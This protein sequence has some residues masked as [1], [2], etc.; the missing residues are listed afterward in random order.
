VPLAVC[1]QIHFMHI[2]YYHYHATS[3][4]MIEKLSTTNEYEED[5][6]DMKM[7]RGYENDGLK[8]LNSVNKTLAPV[9]TNGCCGLGHRL[10][11]LIPTLVYANQHN[12]K[13]QV[14]WP[15]VSWK[16]LFEEN[17]YFESSSTTPPQTE[18]LYFANVDWRQWTTRPAF[19]T[20]GTV[21][22]RYANM[23]LF[24][25]DNG[26]MYNILTA[27]RSSFTPL[28]KTY[29]DS[30]HEGLRVKQVSP[31]KQLSLC[32]HVREGNGETGDWASKKWRHVGDLSEIVD[33]VVKKMSLVASSKDATFVSVFVASDNVAVVRPAF[34]EAF[35][36]HSKAG[37]DT[38]DNNRKW[39]VIKPKE[40]HKPENGVW[41]G[42]HG[43]NTSHVLN[44]TMKTEAMAEAISQIF[45]LGECD[46][47]FV[48]TYSTFNLPAIILTRGRNRD[49]YVSRRDKDQKLEMIE[50][51][52]LHLPVFDFEYI[53]KLGTRHH[54]S[55]VTVL[56]ISPPKTAEAS[57]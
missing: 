16:N 37:N 43:S 44:Q 12:R 5:D 8:S 32:V 9:W 56:N 20:T 47:L 36:K 13:A 45:G 4:N 24:L 52:D 10:S 14:F 19:L 35:A 2:V 46:A 30:I 41:F 17:E 57:T 31:D 23:H 18:G 53:D 11:S 26:W 15:D 39:S 51:K 21:L 1:L 34:A 48:P 7:E 42:A 27:L 50:I 38:A 28:I 25:S 33:A 40:I 3:M 54:Q 55:N 29:F 22:D 6:D 49:V